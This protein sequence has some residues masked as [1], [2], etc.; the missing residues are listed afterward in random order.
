MANEGRYVYRFLDTVGD[1]TGVT[2]HSDDFS[3][4][5]E[6][7]QVDPP[8]QGFFAILQMMVQIRSNGMM[9]GEKYGDQPELTDG[10]IVGTFD[11]DDNIIV[12]LTGGQPIKSNGD[13]AKQAYDAQMMGFGAAAASGD[14]YLKVRWNFADAGQPI[15]ISQGER[16]AVK[17]SDDFSGLISQTAQVQGFF[18]ISSQLKV[19]QTFRIA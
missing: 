7:Y 8:A 19:A 5:E 9:S 1:G 4:T 10:I 2:Q 11:L 16:F 18:C 15:F 14:Q 6:L 17:L 12:D 3:T 13:W